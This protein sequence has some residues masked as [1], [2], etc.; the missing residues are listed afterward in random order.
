MGEV[1]PFSDHHPESI[2]QPTAGQALF[3]ILVDQ[4]AALGVTLPRP[5]IAIACKH[6]VSALGDGVAP[7]AVLGGCLEALRCGKHRYALDFIG[8][9]ALVQAGAYR[10]Q[11]SY[12]QM[13][14]ARPT[15]DPAF[16]RALGLDPEELSR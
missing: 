13:L 2:P 8:E 5:S 11:R 15:F 12:R 10:S 14:E 3:A 16:A 9:A 1:V 7:E 6:G 4:L